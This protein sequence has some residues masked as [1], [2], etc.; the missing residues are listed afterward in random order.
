MPTIAD[1]ASGASH[2]TGNAA[3][4]LLRVP[5]ALSARGLSQSSGSAA[6]TI[7]LP[8]GAINDFG[9]W[10]AT[11]VDP[12]VSCLLA[13]GTGAPNS[14]AYAAATAPITYTTAL[15]TLWN[16]A[17]N[18]AIRATW[19]APTAAA[20]TA[21]QV[22]SINLGNLLSADAADYRT[23]LVYSRDAVF[24]GMTIFDATVDRSQ[25]R[26]LTGAWCGKLTNNGGLPQ[27]SMKPNQAAMATCAPGQEITGSVYVAL[28]R[29]N[30]QWTAGIHF[31]DS[32]F[33]IIGTWSY[34]AYATHPGG[35]VY[36]QSTATATAPSGTAYVAVV[37]HITPAAIGDGEIAYVDVHRITC[38]NIAARI[39]PSAFQPA[40]EQIVTVAANRV[41]EVLNP[42]FDVDTYGWYQQGGGAGTTYGV[43]A[44]VGRTHVGAAKID[45]HYSG[46]SLAP[47][48]GTL[49][50]PTS[51]TAQLRP[52]AT[53][54][55]SVYIL[56]QAGSPAINLYAAIGGNS[57][58]IVLGN[59]TATT[60]VIEGGW[61]R[62]WVTFTVPLSAS[63]DVGVWIY[64]AQADWD[65][66]A[67][68]VTWWVDDAMI[69]RSPLL[70]PYFDAAEPSPDYL[71]EAAA[72]RSRS[73]YY[74]DFRALQYRL[75]GLVSQAV[76]LGV[77]Y[78]IMY[79]QP[80]T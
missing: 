43:D 66:H 6:D 3:T 26:P 12:A 14:R 39:A 77:P 73:H 79:A 19:T 34:T 48:T 52:G 35:Y 40:R 51:G 24:S 45:A 29:A 31:Y 17:V 74:R 49:G 54:T 50:Q 5:G 18:A 22:E 15:G 75:N 11:A 68:N 13:L 60:T 1:T 7:V 37:P 78:Q 33:N 47:G 80:D 16:G 62:L 38:N 42:S 32:S 2:S 41:N 58:D 28:P 57:A 20:I 46:G 63:G 27:Y 53:Y 70:N 67:A 55:M 21:A 69:E 71:W 61:Y 23:K 76:P 56:P 72:Y 44:G 9:I 65:A 64:V 25:D 30:A 4:P 59:S 36:Q 10:D 8:V